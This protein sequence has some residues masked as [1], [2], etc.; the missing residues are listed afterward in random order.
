MNATK[1]FIRS[2]LARALA[3]IFG[4]GLVCP[5]LADDLTLTFTDLNPTTATLPGACSGTA[6]TDDANFRMCSPADVLGGGNPLHKDSM[7][8]GETWTFSGPGGGLTFASVAGTPGNPGATIAGSAAPTPNTNPTMQK[9]AVFFGPQFNF[10]APFT[11]SL[12]GNA[13]GDATYL[14]LG[15]PAAGNKVPLVRFPVTE[16]QWGGTWFPLGQ[17][18]SVGVTFVA[19]VSNTV[20]T[21]ATTTFDFEM[22]ANEL[23]D[24]S[25]DPGSAGFSGWTAQWHMSG[26]GTYTDTTAPTLASTNPANNGTVPANQGN[27]AAMFNE[28]MN[29]A[30]VTA[31]FVT[32]A[33]E[34][35]G[36]PVTSDNVTFTFPITSLPLNCNPC[37]VSFN[38]AGVTDAGGNALT[39]PAGIA[40][41]VSGAD[42]T[43]PTLAS[44]NPVN[45]AINVATG[46]SVVV[47]FSE[48]MNVASVQAAFSLTQ[49]GGGAVAG[50]LAASNGNMTFTFS[51]TGGLVDGSIYD[52]AVTTAAQDAAGLPLLAAFASSFTTAGATGSVPFPTVND[53]EPK[54]F[55]GL[56]SFDPSSL[57]AL[58]GLA[59][60]G[61]RGRKRR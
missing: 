57:L 52:V 5:A 15:P 25:E 26:S 60:L 4:A 7:T 45:G 48:P 43:N 36:S 11:G 49:Q 9:N 39:A 20:T 44:V 22:W 31:G 53:E 34:T 50:S 10:L 18:G 41:N 55:A 19:D 51:P 21:G 27:F 42:T 13:Y 17:N 46:T 12:A 40:F 38:A 1:H 8:G 30:S 16:A 6:W 58:A 54:L 47:N 59:W 2:D 56:G 3:A 32:I 35:V 24:V 28:L 33:G 23:I 37:A 61:R 14:P 29:P